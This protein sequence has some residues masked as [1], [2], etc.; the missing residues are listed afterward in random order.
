MANN[1]TYIIGA[2]VLIVV[3][4]LAVLLTGS[5]SNNATTSSNSQQTTQVT[6]A[7]SN[8][9]TSV[10]PATRSTP[11]VLTDPPQVP[12]GTSALVMTYSNV[13]VQTAGGSIPGT[14]SANGSGSINLIATTNGT[15]RVLGNADIAANSTINAVSFTITSVTATVNGTAQN[16]TVPNPS[17]TVNVTGNTQTGA[18]P[19][20][21]VD[22]SPTIV[23][24]TSSN[25]T[26]YAMSPSATAVVIGNAN[27]GTSVGIGSVIALNSSIRAQLGAVT[28]SISIVSA[29]ILASGNNTWAN[30]VVM[31]N[32]NG[33]V[34]LKGVAIYGKENVSSTH[35]T[36]ASLNVSVGG[37]VSAGVTA[38]L[39]IGGL[40]TMAFSTT[41]SG[42][43][44]S[45]SNSDWQGS[46]YVLMPGSKATLYFNGTV[47]YNNGSVKAT[48]INGMPYRIVV[49][50]N[51]GVSD[52][53][54]AT[55]T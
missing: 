28:P 24:S 10:A 31:N 53:V 51:T 29:Q 2:I 36:G 32:A 46:G 37:V 6:T 7:Y 42:S 30:V 48:L 16:V 17:I 49:F 13:K 33:S 27:A 54:N 38:A 14:V 20:V 9:T 18:N 11:V 26:S 15:S 47:A 5:G 12:P 43:L 41:S 23:T 1:T 3:I 45:A 4:A 22:F 8:G 21:L 44:Q 55:A 25:N 39:H 50:G 40:S 19:L 52:A 35:H 34:V